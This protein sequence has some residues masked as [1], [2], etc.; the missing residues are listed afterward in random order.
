MNK[1]KIITIIL[2]TSI[3]LNIITG[4][5]CFHFFNKYKDEE[6]FYEITDIVSS[7]DNT[8][9]ILSFYKE[10]LELELITKNDYSNEL[11][12]LSEIHNAL[13]SLTEEKQYKNKEDLKKDVL[14]FLNE[15][16]KIFDNLKSAIDLDSD[17][18]YNVATEAE[19]KANEYLQQINIEIAKK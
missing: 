8:L 10:Q 18:Y 16:K 6:C 7:S 11:K 17:N 4:I 15:R 19:R 2:F 9:Q 3:I 14:M 12:E 13:I 1:T 5:L